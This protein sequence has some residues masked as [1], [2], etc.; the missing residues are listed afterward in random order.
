MDF[1][2]WSVTHEI[3]L[4]TIFMK[5]EVESRQ[6]R[7]TLIT[8]WKLK[9]TF[10]ISVNRWVRRNASNTQYLLYVQGC[11][12]TQSGEIAKF[13]YTSR[14]DDNWSLGLCGC[15]THLL[16]S[17]ANYSISKQDAAA[18]SHGTIERRDRQRL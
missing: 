4:C 7:I 17:W 18:A 10:N 2:E 1:F 5:S 11:S 6:K 12:P 16:C 9:I 14:L 3:L 8:I 15:G 13:V